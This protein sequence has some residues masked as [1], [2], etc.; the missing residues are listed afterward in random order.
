MPIAFSPKTITRLNFAVKT[1]QNCSFASGS[2]IAKANAGAAAGTDI[3]TFAAA[4][5]KAKLCLAR[6]DHKAA[7]LSGILVKIQLAKPFVKAGLV[8]TEDG[9]DKTN[10]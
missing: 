8:K 7:S 6:K 10:P 2:P 5:S 9:P 4:G 1:K 3:S